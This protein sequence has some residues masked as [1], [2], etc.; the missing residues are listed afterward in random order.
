MMGLRLEGVG[1]GL[2][3]VQRHFGIEKPYRTQNEF[4]TKPEESSIEK[5][6]GRKCSVEKKKVG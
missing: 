2:G 1:L 4:S 6:N 5:E 3:R